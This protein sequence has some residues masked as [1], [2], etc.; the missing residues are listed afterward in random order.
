MEFFGKPQITVG[1]L[2]EIYCTWRDRA[3]HNRL[4]ASR[5]K[6]ESEDWV[7]SHL[8]QTRYR[9]NPVQEDLFQGTALRHLAETNRTNRIPVTRQCLQK[10][11]AIRHI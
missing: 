5:H 7:S 6:A 4:L 3:N 1:G 8:H 11:D 2:K 9:G 10:R